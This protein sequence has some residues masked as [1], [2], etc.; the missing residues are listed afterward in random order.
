[1]EQ[2]SRVKEAAQ[3]YSGQLGQRY[4]ERKIA[5]NFCLPSLKKRLPV[6]IYYE[7]KAITKGKAVQRL[8]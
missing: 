1:M 7:K 5:E 8:K 2:F 4:F 3:F 6:L